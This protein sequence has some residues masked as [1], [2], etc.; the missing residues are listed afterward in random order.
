M[1][2][3]STVFRWLDLHTEFRDQY[4]RAREIQAELMADELLS[5][6]DDA[7]GDLSKGESG[8]I[9]NS[10]AVHRSKL[11]VETRKWIASRLLPK[12]FGEKVE[13]GHSGEMRLEV[14]SVQ[15]KLRAK[16]GLSALNSRGEA[17]G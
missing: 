4:A 9:G 5:I 3:K 11:M 12:K 14:E 10:A 16:L 2:H 7:S 1:P 15:Q 8:P 6:A 17:G 13:V